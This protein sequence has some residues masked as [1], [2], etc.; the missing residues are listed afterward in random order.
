MRHLVPE[1]LQEFL[2]S[3]EKGITLQSRVIALEEALLH[4]LS[5]LRSFED[6]LA[7]LAEKEE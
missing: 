2:P 4:V 6:I 1:H 5:R 3:S 7:V